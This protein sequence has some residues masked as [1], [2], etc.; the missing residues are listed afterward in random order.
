MRC[1]IPVHSG[2]GIAI[3]HLGPLQFGRLETRTVTVH[4][5]RGRRA[6]MRPIVAVLAAS[7]LALGCGKLSVSRPASGGGTSSSTTTAVAPP[8]A[9]MPKVRFTSPARGAFLAT[10]LAAVEGEVSGVGGEPVTT[11]TVNGAPVAIDGLGRFRTTATLEY[12]LNMIEAICGDA[13]GRNGSSVIGVLAGDYRAP[14]RSVGK[15]LVTRINDGSLDAIGKIAEGA[16]WATDWTDVFQGINPIIDQS[17]LWASVEVSI[18]QVRFRDLRA[19]MNANPAGLGTVL[20]VDSPILDVTIVA[21]LGLGIIVGPYPGVVQAN[22][23]TVSGILG[24]SGTQAG[25]VRTLVGN[26]SVVFDGFQLSVSNGTL[27]AAVQLLARRA[28]ENALRDWITGALTNKLV[29]FMDRKLAEYLQRQTPWD[30]LG[31][32]FMIDVR[33]ERFHFDDQGVAIELS[34]NATGNVGAA[35]RP[36]PSVPGSL[37]TP[38]S[39]PATSTNRGFLI[40]LD[41]DAVNRALFALWAGGHMDVELDDAFLQSHNISLPIRLEAGSLRRFL[42]EIGGRIPDTAPVKLHLHANL[43]PCVKVTGQPDIAI[44]QAGEVVLDAYVDR[45]QGWEKLMSAVAQIEIGANLVLTGQGLSVSSLSQ[46][47]FRFDL[48]DEPLVELDDRRLETLLQVVLTPL[49]P[50]AMNSSNV[51]WIPHLAQLQTVNV[52]SYADGREREHVSVSGDLLR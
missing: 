18:D 16:L 49:V 24:A 4:R 9:E 42:P 27:D 23:A 39:A 25:E 26:P 35:A 12:G 47:R 50:H 22:T 32:P 30:I 20:S 11:L 28:I 17:I 34:F 3:S 46:P 52:D 15:A 6:S 43:P 19:S 37:T 33:A 7:C 45:G 40:S 5:P 14:D 10:G 13:R 38:G 36:M 41:D 51:I 31:K 29:P 21:D 48:V 1:G 2:S 44:A 8:A